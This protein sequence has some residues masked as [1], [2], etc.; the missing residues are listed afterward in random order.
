MKSQ[1]PS[2][3][4]YK[5]GLII[6][7]LRWFIIG[8]WFL[9]MLACVPFLPNIISPFKTTG[10]VDESSQSTKT[11][12]YLDKKLDYSRYNKFIIVYTSKTLL[13]TN[14]SYIHKLKHSL[15]D[16][17]NFPIKHDIIYP[18]S[19]AKQIS[20]DKHTAYVVVILKQRERISDT[21]L[22]QFTSSIK[23]PSH[24]TMQL[25]G[26]AI[27]NNDVNQQTE[28]DL[29]KADFVAT[30][31]AIITLI[32]VFG[33]LIAALLP[34]ILGGGCALLTLTTL[35]F[36]G[37][38]FTLSIFT[39]NI[40]L[41]LG[42]CLSLDYALFIISRF[43]DELIEQPTLI[44]AIAVTQATAGRAVFFSGIA[45]FAS[46]SALLLFPINILF[47][48]GVGGLTAVLLAVI[49]AILFL[50][51]IL[52][53][54]NSKINLLPVKLFKQK[55]AVE[56]TSSSDCTDPISL[57]QFEKNRRNPM[58]FW[59]WLTNKIVHY[60]ITFF[61]LT[62]ALLLLLGYPFLSAK[63]GVSDFHIFP[64]HS[65]YRQF[66][67]TYSKEFNENELTPIEIVVKT[68]SSSILSLKNLTHLSELTDT[69]KNDPLIKEVNSIVTTTPQLTANQYYALYHMPKNQMNYQIKALLDT[70]TR[71]KF[72]TLSVISRFPINSPNTKKL[73]NKLRRLK[74][75]PGMSMELTGT[76]VSNHDVLSK[77]S[78]ILPY[79]IAWIMV[80][81][82]LILLILL[83]SLFLPI[84]AII[85]NLLSLSACFG[86]LVLV[87][88]DGYLHQFLN[89]EPQGLL[90]ISLLVIIF[91]ALF[92]FSMDYEVFLLTRIK[93]F[94]LLTNN[95]KKSII[96]GLEK[97]RRIITSAAVIVIFIC[98]S[99][100]VADVLMVKAFG[101]G[102]A[103]AIFMD[104][105]V[106]RTVLVPSTMVLLK[107]WNWYL[108]A[109]LDRLLPK[110]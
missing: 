76:P 94:Y 45:V 23:K 13:A 55:K 77:I 85:M 16:L 38:A 17:N 51:A 87:F 31:V 58:L 101:L 41:M 12:E 102:I 96:Y 8:L 75:A 100:L 67:N 10:F 4:F 22:E 84:K 25:G 18:D 97:S 81:T 70:T 107:K 30:P 95:S 26:E 5:L 43:R 98:G 89:F 57:S 39:L 6:Y 52:A 24:M 50:P 29:Y 108:P 74:I 79:A 103:V 72:T 61:L 66:F 59:S 44:Q 63:F 15:S 20:K 80:L 46:L 21:L 9:I 73:I 109:W 110:K 69:L 71:H 82:Y 37:H 40:A 91:C 27:F 60:P 68:H 53:V 65:E 47:S 2:K 14:P 92:G 83:R 33:S 104:A 62:F 88:Q 42:L 1:L 34:V 78:Q 28:K 90:D 36:L 99:F 11:S 19:N 32:I 86:A 49:T 35:Y 105:F 48:V 54:L 56:S 106:I 3:R 7:H 64:E 93:E